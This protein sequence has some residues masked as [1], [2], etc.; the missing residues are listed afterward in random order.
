MRDQRLIKFRL[1]RRLGTGGWRAFGREAAELAA[2]CCNSKLVKRSE[3]IDKTFEIGKIA[4][5]SAP[6]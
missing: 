1:G 4:R 3:S 6:R 5:L 2:K